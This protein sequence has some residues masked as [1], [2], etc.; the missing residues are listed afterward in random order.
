MK[1]LLNAVIFMAVLAILLT[2]VSFA[3]Y[4]RP[5]NLAHPE[6][7]AGALLNPT[8]LGLSAGGSLLP[9]VTHSPA[10]GCWLPS[11]VC[12]DW[13]PIAVGGSMVAGHL[14]FDVGPIFNVLPWMQSGFKA[15]APA[16]WGWAQAITAKAGKEPVTF[17][18]GPVWQYQQAQNRGAFLIFTGLALHF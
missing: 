15:V 14:T 4:F 3:A 12:E 17:S 9:L 10:D 6:P 16:N 7:V 11:F 8:H 13:S 18:A 1:K 5:I 2:R